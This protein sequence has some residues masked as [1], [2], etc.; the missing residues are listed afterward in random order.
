LIALIGAGVGAISA[1]GT[2][3]FGFYSKD[4]ELDIKMVDI[5][6][7]ILKGE[8]Q[9]TKTEPARRFALRLLEK[10]AAVEI[11]RAEFDDW[12]RTGV[13]PIEQILPLIQSRLSI[14]ERI[15]DERRRLEDAVAALEQEVSGTRRQAGFGPKARMYIHERNEIENRLSILNKDLESIENQ[16]RNLNID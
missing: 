2:G 11:P 4:R 1:L 16:I 13:L 7:A 14:N 3:A 10:Y 5:A 9:G 12:V 8:N 6:L 15:A